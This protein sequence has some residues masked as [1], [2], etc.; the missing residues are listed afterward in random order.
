MIPKTFSDV[1]YIWSGGKTLSETAKEFGMTKVEVFGVF[2]DHII[3]FREELD[4]MRKYLNRNES[5]G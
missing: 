4:G 5:E 2:V 1:F 3:G